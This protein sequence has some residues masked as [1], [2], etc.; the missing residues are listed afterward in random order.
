MELNEL[1]EN[2]MIINK[3]IYSHCVIKP[4]VIIVYLV[5]KNQMGKSRFY[6]CD[7]KFGVRETRDGKSLIVK[8]STKKK[9]GEN[10]GN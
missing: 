6:I 4:D 10:Y 9:G 3:D 5:V 7:K 2:E 8:L 1:Q